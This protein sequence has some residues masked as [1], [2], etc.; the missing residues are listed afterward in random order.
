MHMISEKLVRYNENSVQSNRLMAYALIEM[1]KEND[2][3][4]EQIAEG[5]T[6]QQKA[7]DLV[8]QEV[9][10]EQEGDQK[11]IALIN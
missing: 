5:I 8:M 9:D 3:M 1:N 6:Y 2:F 10:Q 11:K 7:L 4:M